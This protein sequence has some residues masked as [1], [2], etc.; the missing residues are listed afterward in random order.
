MLLARLQ[1][2]VVSL[3]LLSLT[4]CA[5]VSGDRALTQVR[6]VDVTP[7]APAV[8]LYE[9]GG[10][11]LYSIGFGTASSYIPMVAGSYTFSA[12]TAGLKQQLASASASLVAGGQY[13][14][15]LSNTAAALQMQVVRDQAIAAP[16][17]EF[18]L[19][20][21]HQSTRTGAVDLYL[22]APGA[23]LAAAKPFASGV[24]FGNA[25]LY[26]SLPSGTYSLVVVPSSVPAGAVATPMY[27]GS[28]A[29]YPSGVVRTVVLMDVAQ[30][31]A[32]GVQALTTSDYD[33]M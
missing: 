28:Q 3:A 23:R 21:L 4:G 26:A 30:P 29:E 6:F 13:T 32:T 10:A 9:N 11:M 20:V 27:T 33:P 1:L 7:D 25:P 19:R 5:V 22:L 24:E 16:Q 15:L 17:G 2:G 14:I 12:E 8:D 31:N 18:S